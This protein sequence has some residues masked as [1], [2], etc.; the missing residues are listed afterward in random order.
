M[1]GISKA[2]DFYDDGGQ[3]LRD[4][5]GADVPD[6]IKE[7]EILSD[8]DINN[9]PDHAFAVVL[10]DG[11]QKMRK[12]ACVDKAH[13]AV[14]A[15][16]L[17]ENSR[18]LPYEA[19]SVAAHNIK[20]ACEHFGLTVPERLSKLAAR[21]KK[22]IDTDGPVPMVPTKI[23]ASELSG[24]NVMPLSSGGTNKRLKKIASPF[25]SP[26]VDA[27]KDVYPIA[28]KK[29]KVAY[30][31]EDVNGPQFP[32]GSY[33][34]VKEAA[35]FFSQQ[36]RRFHPR[37]RHEACVKIA[38]RAD[39]IGVPVSDVVSQYGS[40]NFA[41]E[42]NI[43]LGFESR[44]QLFRDKGEDDSI[45]LL[46]KLLEKKASSSPEEFVE[47]L[48][49]LDIALGIS[50][51]WDKSVVDPWATVFGP[52]KNAEWSW[53]H[54][55]EQVTAAQLKGILKEGPNKDALTAAFGQEVVDTM[56]KNPTQIFDSMP[57]EQKIVIAR[58]AYQN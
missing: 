42:S 45:G 41:S 28:F 57:L 50:K 51:Y 9:L 35:E 36:G 31:L 33:A 6:L 44:K 8:E 58:L 25:I 23:K 12:F 1:I 34:Q 26:Y 7:A 21:S 48:S 22:L 52:E 54:G 24:T 43:K 17:M 20:V 13:S 18:S 46:D 4:K 27:Q 37:R 29:E 40:T 49:E 19:R 55:K 14:N 3:V 16:Y 11:G 39:A 30:A 10:V 53:K 15:I 5:F 56:S 32:L 2:V 38:A 47:A